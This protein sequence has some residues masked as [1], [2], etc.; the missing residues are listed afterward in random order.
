M[1]RRPPRSTLCQTLFPYTTLFRPHPPLP[2]AGAGPAG[3]RAGEPGHGAGRGGRGAR[4]AGSAVVA[5]DPAAHGP[6]LGGSPLG[7]A[8]AGPPVRVRRAA[9]GGRADAP[10]A[11]PPA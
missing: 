11:L 1:I 7:G 5:T 9:A 3:R 4:R 8:A 6:A 2:R 10:L